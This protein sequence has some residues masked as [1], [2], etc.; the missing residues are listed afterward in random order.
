[1][2]EVHFGFKN[3]VLGNPVGQPLIIPPNWLEIIPQKSSGLSRL[4]MLFSDL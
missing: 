1:M 4:L 3:S 2:N